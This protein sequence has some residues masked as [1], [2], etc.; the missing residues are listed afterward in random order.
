MIDLQWYAKINWRW[1]LRIFRECFKML[2][3]VVWVNILL[4]VEFAQ[5]TKGEFGN[6]NKKVDV[7]YNVY[8]YEFVHYYFS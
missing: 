6:E 3:W 8:R 7:I 5:K 4:Q 2:I 1:L